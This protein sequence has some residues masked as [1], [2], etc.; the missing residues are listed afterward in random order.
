MKRAIIL[1]ASVAVV[2]TAEPV[3]ECRVGTTV[4]DNGLSV[5]VPN[6]YCLS[7]IPQVD[8]GFGHVIRIEDGKELLRFYAGNAGPSVEQFEE[9]EPG[10]ACGGETKEKESGQ[11]MRYADREAFLVSRSR[12]SFEAGV[13]CGV[14]SWTARS[15]D[16]WESPSLL[17]FHYRTSNPQFAAAAYRL[18]LSVSSMPGE[19][20]G[21]SEVKGEV[22]H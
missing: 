16:G 3:P 6:G 10:E 17:L 1:L 8:F 12:H 5:T 11:V 20:D 9:E 14:T 21:A 7:E 19:S 13:Q 2:L 15:S 22:Q 4:L 18:A